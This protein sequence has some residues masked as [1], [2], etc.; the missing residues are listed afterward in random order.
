ML[1]ALQAGKP[2]THAAKAAGVSRQTVYSWARRGDE[3]LRLA[4]GMGG[5]VRAGKAPKAPERPTKRPETP[6]I[7]NETLQKRAKDALMGLL[8]DE[9][10][11]WRAE[12]AKIVARHFHHAEG[13][14]DEAEGGA[15]DGE[16]P[17][18]EAAARFRV[19]S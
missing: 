14:T 16:I 12:A 19:V 4:L 9:D 7:S 11:R 3:E 8:S 17:P 5:A 1:A 6:A 2:V 10:P 15:D 13:P 18:D